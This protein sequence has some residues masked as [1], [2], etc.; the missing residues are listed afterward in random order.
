[1][2]CIVRFPPTESIDP[3]VKQYVGTE[4]DDMLKERNR[5]VFWSKE[6]PEI[7]VVP[8]GGHRGQSTDEIHAFCAKD[9]GPS[10]KLPRY[11]SS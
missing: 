6:N 9:Q 2:K 7:E 8:R 11:S 10:I 4:I 5:V 3:Q 1:V